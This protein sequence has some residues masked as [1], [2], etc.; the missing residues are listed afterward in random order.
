[1]S[2]INISLPQEQVN[3][4]DALVSRYGFA[5]RS[6]FVRGII[7]LLRQ[8]PHV[9]DDVVS[10]PFIAAPKGQSV[11]EMMADFRKVGKYSPAF[12]KSLEEGLKRSRYF[13]P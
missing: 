11:K 1:M 2:T 6:E 13:K 12:L 7:R 9:V 10:Y 3:F 4:I 8:K 5:N